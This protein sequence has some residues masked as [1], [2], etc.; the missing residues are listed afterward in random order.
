MRNQIETIPASY[1]P[2]QTG[3]AVRPRALSLG[4]AAGQ[5]RRNRR[6]TPPGRW[7]RPL[8]RHQTAGQMS[9]PGQLPA[10]ARDSKDDWLI[11]ASPVTGLSSKHHRFTA[12][13]ERRRHRIAAASESV[14]LT[15]EIIL[16]ARAVSGTQGLWS[17]SAA[18]CRYCGST[19]SHPPA[20]KS[21]RGGSSR[22]ASRELHRLAIAV[23]ASRVASE[24]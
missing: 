18:G 5:R 7:H 8:H 3:Q 2:G 13:A 15:P 24:R 19:P 12:G 1:V 4:S 23:A 10:M 21:G 11:A 17:R 22:V 9:R 16:H 14:T 6:R 20:P